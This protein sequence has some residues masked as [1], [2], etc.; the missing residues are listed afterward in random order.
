MNKTAVKFLQNFAACA[1]LAVMLWAWADQQLTT[2]TDIELSVR[3]RAAAGRAVSPA[4]FAVNLRIEGPQEAVND[5]RR[6]IQSG[7]NLFDYQVGLDDGGRGSF[8]IPVLDWLRSHEQLQ[9][10][11]ITVQYCTP[12]SLD[13]EVDR[14][15]EL[16]VTVVD[17]DGRPLDDAVASPA[18][19]KVRMLRGA[20]ESLRVRE[21]NAVLDRA[22]AAVPGA[23]Q[24]FDA[25]LQSPS[26]AVQIDPDAKVKV[27][28]VIKGK[29]RTLENV[30]VTLAAVE[31]ALWRDFV[32]EVDPKLLRVRV[33][34]QGPPEKIDSL[35]LDDVTAFV[36]LGKGN[37]EAEPLD[38]EIR[39][40][41]P[42]GV[43]VVHSTAAES[44]SPDPARIKVQLKKRGG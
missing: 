25:P 22:A 29:R 23:A 40:R 26:S 32:P 16:P 38:S 2:A 5:L 18:R 33:T 42:D 39:F 10:R 7:D 44:R 31:P 37:T 24:E 6:L 27:S 12:R 4:N 8:T 1:V 28:F 43:D 20:Y 13:V 41:L 3:V 19:V 15:Y 17:K 36:V 34:V 14:E 30:P 21:I 11:G 35:K 9:G